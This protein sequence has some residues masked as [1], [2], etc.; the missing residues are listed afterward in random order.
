MASNCYA[1]GYTSPQH[2]PHDSAHDMEDV[3]ILTNLE[4]EVRFLTEKVASAC[5]SCNTG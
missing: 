5:T 2:T 3:S 4:E 1:N